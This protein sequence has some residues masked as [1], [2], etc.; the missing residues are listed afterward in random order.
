VVKRSLQR[1]RE[2]GK[3]EYAFL[4]VQTV[5]LYPQLAER[6]DLPVKQ[7]AWVQA[8]TAGGPG[9]EGGIEG[10]RGDVRFQ[11]RTFSEGGDIITK[12]GDRPVRDPSDL[13]TAV[14]AFNPGQKVKVE[15][16]RDGE[17]REIEVELGKRPLA[18]PSTGR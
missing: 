5:P 4:G 16:W 2:D 18:G 7:G 17:R 11:A 12:V 10:G 14:Q 1:L 3:V 9:D 15:V 13:S 8:I 6:F